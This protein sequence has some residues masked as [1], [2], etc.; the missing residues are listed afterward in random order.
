MIK[1]MTGLGVG[2][3]QKDSI[4]YN[5]EIRS[6][7]NRFLEISSRFPGSISRYEHDI[8]ELIRKRI[9]RGKLYITVSIQ[10]ANGESV[11]LRVVPEKAR[12]I[13]KLLT[14]LK[15]ETGIDEEVG[16]DHLLK[17]SEIFEAGENGTENG[18]HWEGIREALIV[19][20]DNL[21]TMR[22]QEGE[23]LSFDLQ[24]RIRGLKE[25][26]TTIEQ[27][28]KENLA[29]K[30]RKLEERIQQLLNQ[31]A[32]DEDRL[33]TEIAILS[34]K[35]DVTEECVR[36]KSHNQIFEETLEKGQAVG[37]KLNFLLQE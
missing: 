9:E 21:D 33:Y 2:E 15:C 30:H 32:M 20:I 27:L 16:L 37:K 10:Q 4:T 22:Q 35:L 29:E 31:H 25:K 36:L 12:L 34:D 23:L 11:G 28:A 8:R 24:D 7:N 5:I 14:D 17:F 13:H 18:E 26:V 6:V 19:T 3:F 1:S